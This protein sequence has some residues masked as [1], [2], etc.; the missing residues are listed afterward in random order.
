[1]AL[2]YLFLFLSFFSFWIYNNNYCTDKMWGRKTKRKPFT[3][4]SFKFNS[5]GSRSKHTFLIKNCSQRKKRW[6]L[7]P[8]RPWEYKVRRK[9]SHFN[10]F[11]SLYLF[12]FHTV[13]SPSHL[14]ILHFCLKGSTYWGI[15][16]YT[17]ASLP[18]FMLC[19]LEYFFEN[20]M[21]QWVHDHHS[22]SEAPQK[23]IIKKMSKTQEL[24]NDGMNDQI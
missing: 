22:E 21:I 7:G 1:M 12:S 23:K 3:P 2:P 16:M 15:S 13:K 20:S 14:Y 18:F 6:W 19:N 10:H 17:Y 4:L 5:K 24:E 9:N 11:Q 8:V